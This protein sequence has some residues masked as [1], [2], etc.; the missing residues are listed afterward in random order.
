MKR[1]AKYY[2][3]NP[4]ARK[5]KAKY[6]KKF[7]KSKK[8]LENRRELGRIRYKAKKNGKKIEGKDFD[9]STGKFEKSSINRGRKEKSRLK[10]SKR[11]KK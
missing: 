8:E 10:G 7:N 9:H 11:K 5:V 4:E 6:Q 3:D 1:T 2:K